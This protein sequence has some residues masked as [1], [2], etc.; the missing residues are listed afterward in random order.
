MDRIVKVLKDAKANKKSGSYQQEHT[1][2]KNLVKDS[3]PEFNHS[4]GYKASLLPN[5]AFKIAEDLYETILRPHRQCFD[6]PQDSK[7]AVQ[8]MDAFREYHMKLRDEWKVMIDSRL[9]ALKA[10][11]PEAHQT[12]EFKALEHLDNKLKF[13]LHQALL[14]APIRRATPLPILTPCWLEDY[15]IMLQEFHDGAAAVR[16]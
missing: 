8:W 12:D 1:R 6:H 10:V 16:L 4:V 14:P 11:D 7:E 3:F 2:V 13:F 5:D 9:N 15:C